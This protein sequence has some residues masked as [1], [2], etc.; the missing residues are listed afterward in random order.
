MFSFYKN[1]YKFLI[2]SLVALVAG[3]IVLAIFGLNLDIQ[4]KGGSILKYTF[5]GEIDLTKADEI[6]ESTLGKSATLQETVDLSTDRKNLVVSVAGDEA[7]STEDQ[8]ALRTALNENFAENNIEVKE[9][10]V[11]DPFIGK[12]TLNKGLLAVVI[13]AVLIV[14]YVWIRF[15]TIS[16]PSAGVFSLLALLHDVVLTFFVFILLRTPLNDTLIAVMLSILGW[17]VNDTI[18]IFDRI[19]E[20]SRLRE[21]KETLPEMVDRSINQMLTRSITTSVCAFIAVG[22]AYGFALYYNIESI[23]HFALPMMIGIVIGTYSSIFLATPFWAQW[24]TRG[25]RVGFES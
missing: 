14:F 23:R 24:M 10:N 11:V 20:N 13:A 16:G 17:S 12:E 5:E 22:I 1:R 8:T 9:T 18:V 3:I 19:R 15:R 25:G 2:L 7:L 6:V 21:G 4:F